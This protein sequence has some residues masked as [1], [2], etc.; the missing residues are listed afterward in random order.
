M[1]QV[2]V[3]SKNSIQLQKKKNKMWVDIFS[4]IIKFIAKITGGKEKVLKDEFKNKMK[5][6]CHSLISEI[7]MVDLYW[8]VRIVKWGWAKY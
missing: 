8:K 7:E 2:I 3:T 4:S 6:I 1:K 5:P